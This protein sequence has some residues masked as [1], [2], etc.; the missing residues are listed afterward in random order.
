[1]TFDARLRQGA[2]PKRALSE[3]LFHLTYST[4]QGSGSAD[5]GASPKQA[6]KHVMIA[7]ADP[8]VSSP[9]CQDRTA[10]WKGQGVRGAA[11]G[12]NGRNAYQAADA[13]LGAFPRDLHVYF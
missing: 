12:T 11:V 10:A 3:S 5:D 2:P 13:S 4:T 1:M 9:A 7:V 8:R 6:G